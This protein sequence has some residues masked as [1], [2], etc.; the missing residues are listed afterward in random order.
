M[1]LSFSD[2]K[3]F[4]KKKKNNTY[5]LLENKWNIGKITSV[6]QSDNIICLTLKNNKHKKCDGR[7]LYQTLYN[8]RDIT[9]Q[10]KIK[11]ILI[12]SNFIINIDELDRNI[13]LNTMYNI[14]ET[15]DIN[16][17]I[18]DFRNDKIKA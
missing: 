16:I 9:R 1:N 3:V 10:N 6:K 4:D 12:D 2:K 5:F 17:F 14:F 18:E 7:I 8:V 11:N 13:I 15:E